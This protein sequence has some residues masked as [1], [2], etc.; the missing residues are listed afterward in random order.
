MLFRKLNLL[1]GDLRSCTSGGKALKRSRKYGRKGKTND[2]VY[3][4]FSVDLLPVVTAEEHKWGRYVNGIKN[5]GFSHPFRCATASESVVVEVRRAHSVGRLFNA[6]QKPL[7]SL[8][9][10]DINSI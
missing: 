8:S 4:R 2:V 10:Y 3:P 1:G 6:S 7:K 5:W 9:A